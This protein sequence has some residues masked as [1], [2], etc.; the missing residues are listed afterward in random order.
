M[1]IEFVGRDDEMVQALLA[2]REDQ[3]DDYTLESFRSPARRAASAIRD[4]APL[5][6]GKRTIF[7]AEPGPERTG[8]RPDPHAEGEAPAPAACWNA[9]STPR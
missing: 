1:V 5:K 9:G 7:F 2:N 8:G 6:G 4:E 3:Y